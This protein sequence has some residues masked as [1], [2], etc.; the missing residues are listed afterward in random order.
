MLNKISKTEKLTTIAFSPEGNKAIK[1]LTEND[2][3]KL[4]AIIKKNKDTLEDLTIHIPGCNKFTDN[5]AKKLSE[6]INKCPNLKSISINMKGC[7][8]LSKIGKNKLIQ[9][10]YFNSNLTKISLNISPWKWNKKSAKYFIEELGKKNSL[11]HLEVNEIFNEEE[12]MCLLLETLKTNKKLK[13][14]ALK[15]PIL[16]YPTKFPK[17]LFEVINTINTLSS[18]SLDLSSIEGRLDY[19]KL[20]AIINKN[21]NISSVFLKFHED[22]LDNIIA[23]NFLKN[24]KNLTS[25][26]ID[27]EISKEIGL[28]ESIEDMEYWRKSDQEWSSKYKGLKYIYEIQTYFNTGLTNELQLNSIEKLLS[29]ET[30]L[31]SKKNTLKVSKILKTNVTKETY[32]QA[33]VDTLEDIILRSKNIIDKTKSSYSPDLHKLNSMLLTHCNQARG[34][35][36][37]IYNEYAVYA[38]DNDDKKMWKTFT[39][40]SIEHS[41]KSS[42]IT[43]NFSINMIYSCLFKQGLY[44]E[45]NGVPT[46]KESEIAFRLFNL[47][48]SNESSLSNVIKFLDKK[49]LLNN[50]A[51][52]LDK[53]IT[54]LKTKKADKFVSIRNFRKK[55]RKRK[56]PLTSE[57]TIYRR[58]RKKKL[59]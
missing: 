22:D 13:S 45:K 19:K 55:R 59:K 16:N 28:F 21:T 30:D 15:S 14:L 11:E 2:F 1:N 17:K 43:D 53:E 25:I 35:L 44:N 48:K 49:S 23:T 42:D 58:K 12:E 52:S 8:N 37:R 34:H 46:N 10:I 38:L 47:A 54:S 32:Q 5:E 26:S 33:I 40:K 41:M 31:S 4:A 24:N 56:K 29:N 27:S 7:R 9:P 3:D 51:N 20:D 50:T 18:L 6:A 39:L 57:T 36:T